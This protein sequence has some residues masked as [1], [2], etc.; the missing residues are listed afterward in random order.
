MV[1]QPVPDLDLALVLALVPPRLPM[2]DL[3]LI[4]VS[5]L[6]LAWAVSLPT[7]GLRQHKLVEAYRPA[8][9]GARQV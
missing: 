9:L 3:P 1:A 8:P 7:C 4:L 6:A 5:V 2:L